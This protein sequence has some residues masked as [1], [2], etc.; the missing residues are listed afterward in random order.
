MIASIRSIISLKWALLIGGAR[1]SGQSR[2]QLLV[3]MVASVLFGLAAIALF[4]GLG[5]TSEVSDDTLVIV[6]AATTLGV[7]MFAATTG[8]ETTLDPRQLAAEPLS[9]ARLAIGMLA[10]AVIGPPAVL[11][12]LSG[13]GIFLG[14]RGRGGSSDAIL[15]AVVVIW[16]VSLVLFS[17]TVANLMGA[18]AVG[19]FR[20]LAQTGAIL[21]PLVGWFVVN[22]IME[23]Q[24]NWNSAGL[25]TVARI[26]SFTPPGRLA[27][28][29]TEGGSETVGAV[30]AGISW[31]PL[32][33][34]GS[35]VSTGRLIVTPPSLADASS[36]RSGRSGLYGWFDALLRPAR[37]I[38]DSRRVRALTKR[39]LV[40]KVRNPRQSVNTLAALVVG[41]GVMVLGPLIDG[42]IGDQRTVMLGGMLQFAVLLDGMNSLGNDGPGLWIEIQ[43]GA[44]A[45]DLIRAKV[46]D[47]I[48]TI[49]PFA[50]VITLVLAAI[51]GAWQWLPAAWLLAAGAVIS[52]AGLA[53]VTSSTAPVAMPVG[54]NPFAAGGVG[55]GCLAGIMLAVAVAVLLVLTAPFVGAVYLVSSRSV[56]W[57]TVLAAVVPVAAVGVAMVAMRVAE[58]RLAGNEAALVDKVTYK[59]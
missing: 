19:R 40:T 55:Q 50:L 21:G 4:L 36:M 35:V 48:V 29:F 26:A 46:L 32:L 20:R 41:G 52:A 28:A 6:L 18:F 59:L 3:S 56:I 5:G 44:D 37:G 34:W 24:D 49:G 53:V 7:G 25:A 16:W 31:L 58:Q 8:V 10:S 57:A 27:M 23:N 45:R 9:T 22:L 11:A 42:G 2:I 39:S 43:A 33:V 54:S 51:G 13:L 15:V 14:W 38:G 1:G 17:R 12:G 30:L 47:S